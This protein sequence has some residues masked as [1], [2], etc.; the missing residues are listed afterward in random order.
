MRKIY[1]LLFVAVLLLPAAV[2]AQLTPTDTTADIYDLNNF[3][4]RFQRYKGLTLD[5]Q[6]SG[7]ST[8]NSNT[9]SNQPD[10]ESK[11]GNFNLN[12]KLFGFKY[13]NSLR[14]QRIIQ[15]ALASGLSVDRQNLPDQGNNGTNSTTFNFVPN[16]FYSQT[17]RTY[18]GNKFKVTDFGGN[19]IFQNQNYKDKLV[20]NSQQ[21]SN[22]STIIGNGKIGF[23]RGRIENVSD[24]VTAMFL[25]K[26]LKQNGSLSGYTAQQLEN[27][28]DGIVKARN[29]RYIGDNRFRYIDQINIV[30]SVA[31]ANGIAGSSDVKF[32]TALYDNLVYTSYLRESG[33]RHTFT[34]ATQGSVN[35]FSSGDKNDVETISALGIGPAYEYVNA[36]QKSAYFQRKTTV[37]AQVLGVSNKTNPPL[38]GSRLSNGFEALQPTV[39]ISHAYIYQPNTR[40]YIYLSGNLDGTFVFQNQDRGDIRN[41]RAGLNLRSNYFISRRFSLYLNASA[42]RNHI[43]IN[44]TNN[45]GENSSVSNRTNLSFDSGLVYAFY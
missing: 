37:T 29:A 12:A 17:N 32:F 13:E 26:A 31:R 20:N 21:S 39:G 41:V 28:A 25:L 36:Y 42:V 4:Y 7:N 34:L 22:R 9:F 23:G 5:Y 18:T 45:S 30:D 19:I 14:N 6:M 2:F 43:Q 40:T 10:A 8:K 33:T 27:L 35:R 16:A 24:A 44:S 11:T 15:Y 1:P 38:D 3:K